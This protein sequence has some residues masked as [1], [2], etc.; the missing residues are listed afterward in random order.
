M[1]SPEFTAEPENWH[2]GASIGGERQN[3]RVISELEGARIEGCQNWR[4]PDSE[5][6]RFR[7]G[8]N[9]RGCQN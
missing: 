5:G 3:W 1:T 7:G 9:S 2:K 4:V 6:A 8:A